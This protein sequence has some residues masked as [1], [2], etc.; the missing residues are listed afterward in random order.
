ML[1]KMTAVLVASMVLLS[2]VGALATQGMNDMTMTGAMTPVDGLISAESPLYPVGTKIIV[3]AD[4][5]EGMQGAVGVVSGAYEGLLYA[6]DYVDKDGKTVINHRWVIAEEFTSNTGNAP[7]IGDTV[8]LGDGHM[9]GMGGVGMSAVIVQISI[10]PAY[11]I[12]YDPT[13]GGER[14]L[15]HQWVTEFELE[16][17]AAA[18]VN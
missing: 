18:S 10:G 3:K 5:M 1:R 9:G 11:M 7:T 4:H 17:F 15:Y 14:V 13:N 6:V 12:D 16:P 8:T 2:L